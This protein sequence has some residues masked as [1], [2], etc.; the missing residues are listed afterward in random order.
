[1]AELQRL[2]SA[3]IMHID[4][5]DP[6]S[7]SNN[8]SNFIVEAGNAE[9][10]LWKLIHSKG[11]LHTDVRELYR[12]ARRSYE[13]IILNDHELA[14]L[15]DIE[16]SL[17]ILHYKHIDEYRNRIPGSSVIK[18]RINMTTE[19]NTWTV[20]NKCDN[21]L[22][23]FKSFL[24]EAT[25]FYH[26]LIK[27]IRK[28]YGLPEELLFSG[29]S[30]SS[31]MDS[32]KMRRCLFWCHRCLVCLG[33]LARYR[34]I[35]GNPDGQNSSWSTAATHYLKASTIWPNS[36][37]PH[38]Q[39]AM[40]A[41]YV[42]DELLALYHCIRSLAV[43]E[44]FPHA[45]DNLILLFEKNRSSHLHYLSDAAPFDFS[46]P[47]ERS[48]LQLKARSS[49]TFYGDQL[50]ESSGDVLKEQTELW[51]LFVRMMSY[52]YL[53]PS[54]E[55]FPCIF[56]S[57]VRELEE[58]LLLDDARLNITLE[59]YQHLDVERIGPFRVLQLVSVLIFTIHA[60]SESS[61]LQKEEHTKYMQQPSLIQQA[62]VTMFIFMGR[63]VNRCMM[64]DRLDSSHLLPAIL[65]FTE[66]LV[67]VL[68][69]V[70]TYAIEEKCARA[71]GYFFTGF[72]GLLNQFDGEGGNIGSLDSSLLWEDNVLRGF[73][74]ISQHDGSSDIKIYQE[75]KFG[76]DDRKE[77]HIRMCRIFVAAMKIVN[78]SIGSKKWIIYE[79]TDKKFYTL[80]RTRES[81]E[82][83]AD[84]DLNA[85]R[86]Q[87]TC[88][89]NE[90]AIPTKSCQVPAS[91]VDGKDL[92]EHRSSP[93]E[94]DEVILFKPITRQD[95]APLYLPV[96][97]SSQ[98]PSEGVWNLAA[99]SGECLNRGSTLHLPP[100]EIG[101]DPINRFGAS[102]MTFWQEP[103]PEDSVMDSFTESTGSP[104]F[105]ALNAKRDEP[106]PLAGPPS[107]SAWVVNKDGVGIEEG[108]GVKC[109]N[110]HGSGHTENSASAYLTD[111][112]IVGTGVSD[113]DVKI[114]STPAARFINGYAYH[115]NSFIDPWDA[116]ATSNRMA[117]PYMPPLPSAPLL[118][119][120]ASWFNGNSS[121][122]VEHKNLDNGKGFF[123]V[124][125]EVNSSSNFIGTQGP[126]IFYP[127]TPQFSNGYIPYPGQTNSAR[128]LHQYQVNLDR[129]PDN[130]PPIHHYTPPTFGQFQDHDASMLAPC[131]TNGAHE[132]KKYG[133][134][135]DARDLRSEQQLL[136]KY[137][138]EKE[139]HLQQEAQLGGSA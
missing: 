127:N 126:P 97:T 56:S 118:P 25:E 111:L 114:T 139:W 135:R 44:P 33:D 133:P 78:S 31:T 112:S 122:Y 9:K 41:I 26:C 43:K 34:E 69:R 102:S 63:L 131:V 82:D 130:F 29:G 37:S 138:K 67:D 76:F 77:C 38:N 110:K 119:D 99:P 48:T 107:L 50:R 89:I 40:L 21:Y 95:S 116:S 30:F 3:P 27:K 124:A 121:N 61:K 92:D 59:S 13:K 132:W 100:N 129:N 88:T 75:A 36:G 104:R 70:E 101:I 98:S 85:R 7:E 18:E 113:Q 125:T 117:P 17:W 108:K 51:S 24:S 53:K 91:E 62:F 80:P 93:V 123:S 137:L 90:D 15:Q 86:L 12:K 58:L 55:D 115:G 52:F 109:A 103:I 84:I 83:D 134:F 87:K 46:K 2:I 66:W 73:L 96:A 64:A 19:P 20:Q 4:P 94:E 22:E 79:E 72:V 6:P 16:Y 60:T 28:S 68:N 23:G 81:V 74:P 32:T 128:W 10:Q 120:D 5:A 47:S 71:I 1:M 35:Y 45:W 42:G 106:P 136:L 11:L 57:T 105:R 14:E 54:F 65:V 39:L 49:D 8:T